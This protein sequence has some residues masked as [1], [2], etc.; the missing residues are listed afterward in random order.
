MVRVKVWIKTASPAAAEEESSVFDLRTTVLTRPMRW[1]S[2]EW[3]GWYWQPG[4]LVW[5]QPS[6]ASIAP[7]GTWIDPGDAER[8]PTSDLILTQAWTSSQGGQIQNVKRL[9]VRSSVISVS[10]KGFP[11]FYFTFL[12]HLRSDFTGNPGWVCG[13]TAGLSGTFSLVIRTNDH[14]TLEHLEQWLNH[15]IIYSTTAGLNCSIAE[16]HLRLCNYAAAV[17]LN[18][19]TTTTTSTQ[20]L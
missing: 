18:S 8:S 2:D 15:L 12:L 10:L 19:T 3:T 13:T 1:G 20:A 17:V 4:A 6:R 16:S 7:F 14:L 9:K 5:D 11:S